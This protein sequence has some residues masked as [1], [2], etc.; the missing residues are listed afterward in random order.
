MSA[1]KTRKALGATA[2]LAAMREALLR[3]FGATVPRYHRA[4]GHSRPDTDIDL[5]QRVREVG[6]W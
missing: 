6:E 4:P 2:R 3:L 5:A 1:F